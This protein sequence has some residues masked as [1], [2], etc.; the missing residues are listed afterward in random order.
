M[1]LG[2]GLEAH[3]AEPSDTS[4]GSIEG[5]RRRRCHLVKTVE[6]SVTSS[7]QSLNLETRESYSLEVAAGAVMI[8]A[9]SVFG[10][11]RGMETL[12]QLARRRELRCDGTA[13]DGGGGKVGGTEDGE[14]ESEGEG[15]C[16]AEG[17]LV[18]P[19]AVWPGELGSPWGERVS[20][21]V[22]GKWGH[23]EA[24]FGWHAARDG[25]SCAPAAAGVD[26]AA[27]TCLSNQCLSNRTAL[28]LPC[29][30]NSG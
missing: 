2:L 19:E 30:G 10:A 21:A 3:P 22:F 12:A 27:S 17:R 29:S 18:P 5:R 24:G 7:D 6:V 28:A 8:Q 26:P 15:G 23:I 20:G 1:P 25:P 9:N 4:G 14:G 16:T 13:S 11:L